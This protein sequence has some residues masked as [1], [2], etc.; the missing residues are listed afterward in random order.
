MKINLK[1]LLD[2]FTRFGKKKIL[3][4]SIVLV[5]L[6]S[7]LLSSAIFL[8]KKLKRGETEESKNHNE[9]LSFD[10][11]LYNPALDD[12]TW[13]ESVFARIE[14]ERIAEELRVME[15]SLEEYQIDDASELIKDDEEESTMNSE[16]ESSEVSEMSDETNDSQAEETLS[17]IENFFSEEKEEVTKTGKNDLLSFYEFDNEI[18]TSQDSEGNHILV[19]SM[20]EKVNRFFY[21]DEYKLI[22]KEVWNIPSVFKAVLEKTETYKYF[23]NSKVV[24]E[25]EITGPYTV[26]NVKYSNDG[27]TLSAEKYAVFEDKEHITEKRLF[28]YDDD[29]NLLSDELKEYFYKADDYK[30]LDYS[31]TKKYLYSYNDEGIPP[32]FK[33]FENGILKMHNKYSTE[34]GNFTSRIFFDEGLSV[35]SYYENNIRVRDVYYRNNSIIREKVYE[36]PEK[37]EE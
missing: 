8:S 25:K 10:I 3:I 15:E 23:E 9:E 26:E 24:S 5:A 4:I 21:D 20:K 34:K 14:E 18:F 19:H 30:N 11:D 27:K 13:V 7:I 32:D 31:F 6:I 29:G 16:S 22:K 12:A 28:S 36:E 1:F 2:F 17:E 33:Y 37:S 35:K